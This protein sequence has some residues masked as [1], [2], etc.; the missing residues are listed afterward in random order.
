MTY[1]HRYSNDISSQEIF[2]N[3]KHER[4]KAIVASQGTFEENILSDSN[5]NVQ[6]ETAHASVASQ[7][8]ELGDAE[9]Q[10]SEFVGE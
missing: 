1:K 3:V 5:Y 10:E 7:E 8:M 2:E 6:E 9:L 4:T